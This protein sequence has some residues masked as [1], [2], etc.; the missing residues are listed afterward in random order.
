VEAE[1]TIDGSVDH[2]ALVSHPTC[3]QETEAVATRLVAVT[4]PTCPPCKRLKRETLPVLAKEGY[5]VGWISYRD[6]NAPEVTKVP[7][8]FYYDS[9]GRLIETEIGFRTAEQVK[10]KLEKP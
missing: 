4:S 6:P 10:E 2:Q 5:S 8:L 9:S 3:V 1:T 7:T